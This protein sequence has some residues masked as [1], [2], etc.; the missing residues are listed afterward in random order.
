MGQPSETAG[1]AALARAWET[2]KPAESRVCYDPFAVHMLRDEGKFL[3]LTPEGR[4]RFIEACNPVMSGLLDY[5]VLRTRVIDFHLQDCATKGLRQIVLL[6]AGYDSRAYR[7]AELQGKIKIIEV[8]T[9]ETQENKK[10]KLREHLGSLPNYVTFV[11]VDFKKDEWAASLIQAGLNPSLQTLLIWEGVT[12]YLEPKAVDQTLGFV[13]ANTPAGSSIIFDYLRPEVV[14]GTTQNPLMLGVHQFSA[15]IGEPL[16]FGLKPQD[17][18]QFLTQRGFNN[19]ENLTVEQCMG[20]YLT[21]A[22]GQ[23]SPMKEYSIVRASVA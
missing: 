18:E 14:D 1:R 4:E 12:Y 5:I 21:P 17:V 15:E 6:G 13:T 22:H 11:P 20:K 8:D 2:Q 19:V 16:K 23:R 3:I 10:A 7:F 9:P